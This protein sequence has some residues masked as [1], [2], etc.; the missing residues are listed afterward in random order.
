MPLLEDP[1]LL[2]EEKIGKYMKNLEKLEGLFTFGTQ[3]DIQDHFR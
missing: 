2:K 3:V 1:N